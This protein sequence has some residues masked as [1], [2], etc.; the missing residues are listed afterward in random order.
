[1]I[2]AVV[3]ATRWRK[4]GSRI[5]S[6]PLVTRGVVEEV[7]QVEEIVVWHAATGTV[8]QVKEARDFAAKLNGVASVNLRGHILVA[9]SPLIQ[10]AADIRSERTYGDTADLTNGIRRKTNRRL[11][12]GVDFIPA[13]SG[14]I[15]AEFVEEGRRNGV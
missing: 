9:V 8:V 11:R 2:S 1:C 15:H 14:G 13:P 5:E 3:L 7:P 6:P 12:V 4:S 10:D